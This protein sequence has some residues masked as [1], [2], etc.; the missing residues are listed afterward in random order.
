M[1]NGLFG[2]LL[3]LP[4]ISSGIDTIR[5]LAHLAQGA[6][7]HIE[8]EVPQLAGFVRE[9]AQTVEHLSTGLRERSLGEIAASVSR[10]ARQEPVVF[11]GGAVLAGFVLAR[12]AR[13]GADGRA[14]AHRRF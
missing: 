14:V 5:N 4:G 3:G 8:P 1:T 9:A 10:F 13:S 6:A 12:L 2:G 7:D 11:L